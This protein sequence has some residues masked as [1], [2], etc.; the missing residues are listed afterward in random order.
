MVLAVAGLL[1]TLVMGLLWLGARG[2]ANDLEAERDALITERDL[3]NDANV[4]LS[5]HLQ[6]AESQLEAAQQDLDE[7]LTGGGDTDTDG[8]SQSD[9]DALDD[10][11]AEL[12]AEVERLNSE[13]E[14]LAADLETAV[15]ATVSETNDS[16][17]ETIAPTT[18]PATTVPATT[19]PITTLEPSD[20]PEPLTP[21][22]AGRLLASLFRN[23]VLGPG[24]E[25]CLAQVV[26]NDLGANTLT[27]LLEG[28]DPGADD[29]LVVSMQG[30]AAFCGI[31]PSAIF[32]G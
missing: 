3:A 25:L 6:V 8:P 28:D 1:G 29:A 22:Q 7:A 9:I 10:Q 27:A 32:G 2:D 19:I 23:D 14:A 4:D 24:Q 13:N 16:T 21:A 11:V 17:P 30:A 26:I 15:A 20:A 12:E 31:D 5:T 18:I